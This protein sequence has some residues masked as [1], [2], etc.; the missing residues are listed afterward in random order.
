MRESVK[1]LDESDFLETAPRP[2]T[3]SH[4]P[5][6]RYASSHAAR[7][8]KSR[9]TS[10]LRRCGPRMVEP[11]E[12]EKE[13]PSLVR[14]EFDDML[15][16]VFSSESVERSENLF[17]T[18]LD[19]TRRMRKQVAQFERSAWRP[20]SFLVSV[21]HFTR[22]PSAE[23]QSQALLSLGANLTSQMF[24]VKLRRKKNLR[25]A[26][27]ARAV[28]DGKWLPKGG[29]D[30]RY[31]IAIAQFALC[32]EKDSSNERGLKNARCRRIALC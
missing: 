7:T 18:A 13:L 16:G 27:I 28:R 31:Y 15:R 3:D 8:A 2:N 20:G 29:H 30:L 11:R 10:A 12:A 19:V 9:L 6:P 24:D 22:E 5:C 17:G 14:C 32:V 25:L 26:D 1:E 23:T 21:L 4:S